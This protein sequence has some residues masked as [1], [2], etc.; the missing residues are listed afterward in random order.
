MPGCNPHSWGYHGNDGKIFNGTKFADGLVYGPTFTTG[1]VIGCCLDFR[2]NHIFY[3][4]NGEYLGVAFQ[5]LE[6]SGPGRKT[7]IYPCIGLHSVGERIH[8]NLGKEKFVFN[9]L[10]YM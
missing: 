5:T 4:K 1:D 7:G 3:S 10:K 2:K 9:I 6:L 8:V